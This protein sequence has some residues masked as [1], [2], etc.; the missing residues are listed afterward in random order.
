MQQLTQVIP[1]LRV[2]GV[3]PKH[4]GEMLARVGMVRVK[5]EV[6]KERLQTR[7][8]G[9]RHRMFVGTQGKAAQEP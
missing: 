3:R 4:I 2:V 9:H 1:G 7:P 5:R 8:V 6:G